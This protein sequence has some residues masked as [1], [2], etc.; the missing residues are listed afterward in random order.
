MPGLVAT[1]SRVVEDVGW[2]F[3]SQLVALTAGTLRLNFIALLLPCTARQ[4]AATR[5]SEAYSGCRWQSGF[6]YVHRRRCGIDIAQLD[7]GK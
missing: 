3:A 4:T 6:V 2:S 5:P 1:T 7:W